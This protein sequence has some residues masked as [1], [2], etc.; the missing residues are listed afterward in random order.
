MS[1]V[2]CYEELLDVAE[3]L[4]PEA[5]FKVGGVIE[6]KVAL[7]I[8]DGPSSRTGEILDVLRRCDARATFF[9]HTDRIDQGAGGRR[10]LERMIAEG[11]EIANHMPD[12]RLSLSLSV[13]EFDLEFER[14][15]RSLERVGHTARFFR[16][17]GG[18]YHA[19]RMLPSLQRLDYFHRFIMASYLPWDT[20]LPFPWHYAAHLA[21]G[22]FPGAIFVLHD[23]DQAP[24]NNRLQRSI[25]SL[26]ILLR[27]LGSAGYQAVP[28]GE[29]LEA[30][31]ALTRKADAA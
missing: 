20:H 6:P 15:H 29:L 2:R 17:A 10:I 12:H 8:D 24:G 30:R 3:R 5:L 4:H 31:P 23:G 13:R 18:F 27:R 22:A 21:A 26:G 25:Q 7:T 19:E 16:A 9:V 14:A 1:M 11:H 28:L